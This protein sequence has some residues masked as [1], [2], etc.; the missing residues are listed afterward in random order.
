MKFDVFY[1]DIKL[2]SKYRTE[3]M[4]IAIIGV[5][6]MH[7]YSI[8]KLPL[9][10]PVKMISII[11][12]MAFTETFLF[13]SGL[14]IYYSLSRCDDTL[15]FYKKRVRRL[16]VP[17]ILMAF[18]PVLLYVT[19]NEEPFEYFFYHLS[20][21]DFWFGDSTLGMWYIAVTI[22]LYLIAPCL[23]RNRVFDSSGRLMLILCAWGIV[24]LILYLINN[25][26]WQS[27]G[28]WLAQSPAFLL[29]GFMMSRI[30]KGMNAGLKE[31]V[32]IFL[33]TLILVICAF[34]FPF[35]IPF[36]RILVRLCG[37][38]VLCVLLNILA[39]C[40]NLMDVLHWFGTYSLEL[41]ILHLLLF[42][43]F[44]GL[45]VD[46]L[47]LISASI[48]FS[49]LFCKPVHEVTNKIIDSWK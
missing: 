16:V 48:A 42:Q 46:N 35:V 37:M 14:G 26:Y 9:S 39:S 10:L 47:Y 34:I 27:T 17:Y 21:I 3:L 12:S 23:Y 33:L 8:G 31:F 4:G 29:G 1:L 38:L 30:E 45:G 13:L 41:Y 32:Y 6:I 28:V 44:K 24:L 5:L 43:P 22:M 2:V 40:K 36:S 49:L 25:K 11:P 19:I 20:T 7:F 18:V 15:L